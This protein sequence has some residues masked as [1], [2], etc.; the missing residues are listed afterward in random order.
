MV[1]ISAGGHPYMLGGIHK[2]WDASISDGGHASITD[3]RHPY[4]MT[5]GGHASMSDEGHI[6]YECC[7]TH[8]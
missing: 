3:G 1:G 6:L 5:A 7:R 2:C 8:I 4:H